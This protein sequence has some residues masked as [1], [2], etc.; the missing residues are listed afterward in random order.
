MD[1]I[2]SLDGTAMPEVRVPIL[3][4]C[5]EAST[6]PQIIHGTHTA[7]ILPWQADDLTIQ[8]AL[9]GLQAAWQ[10]ETLLR[11]EIARLEKRLADRIVIE[12]AKSV[13]MKQWGITEEAA[14]EQ[15]RVQSRRQ[16]KQMGEIAQSILD[17]QFLLGDAGP[18]SVSD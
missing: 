7:L 6:P 17:S 4:L 8:F 14:Y 11:E 9:C 18:S 5:T 1:A 16:R 12:K 3:G 2:P 15:L 13:I 10:R